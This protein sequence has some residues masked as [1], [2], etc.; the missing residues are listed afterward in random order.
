MSFKWDSEMLYIITIV[1]L[2]IEK[3]RIRNIKYSNDTQIIH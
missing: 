3:H 2:S 1:K